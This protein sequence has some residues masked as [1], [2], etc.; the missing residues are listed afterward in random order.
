MTS[1]ET[2]AGASSATRTTGGTLRPD[3]I[4]VT[5]NTVIGAANAGP[6]LSLSLTLAAIAATTAYAS[7][8]VILLCAL[9]MIVIANAYRRLNE[10]NANSGASFEWVGRAVSPYLG[11]VAGWLMICAN[12]VGNAAAVTALGPSVLA[13]FKGPQAATWPNIAIDTSVGVIM[14]LIAV[15]GIRLS[16]RIQL[17]LAAAEYGIIIALAVVA[18]WA[19]SR[20]WSG[21]FPPSHSWLTLNGIG[22]K[23]S[24]AAGLLLA[25]FMYVG[26][27]GAINV[28]EEVRGR[29][30]NPGRAVMLCVA[31]LA[32]FYTL[33]TMALQG[34][35]SPRA[36]QHN[37]AAPLVY[38]GQQ[39]GGSWLGRAA[40]VAVALSVIAGV[41]TGFVVTA[42][43]AYGMAGYRVLPGALANVNRRFATPALATLIVGA[44]FVAATTAYLLSTSI[45]GAFTNLIDSTGILFTGTYILTGLAAIVYHRRRILTRPADALTVGLLP[46][47]AMGF[48][49][50]IVWKSIAAAA[51]AQNWS[52][53]GIIGAGLVI[54]IAVRLL[55]RPE[56]FQTAREAA[57]S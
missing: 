43:I 28:N 41:G 40:A 51:P 5:L 24:L 34:A 29:Q 56:Y 13:V 47:A 39:L 48:L 23:G 44:V 45:A 16:A 21:T 55:T 12:L 37:A 22:G 42:R 30:V 35:V 17:S 2:S 53:L 9:P 7:G 18:A 33:C 1:S 27:D 32:L 49:G 36:L 4:G 11:F 25:V 20:H 15:A 6:G 50:W 19:W 46:V 8:P 14:V 52:L 31:F 26:W 57:S 3:A 10:W 38:I 54:M